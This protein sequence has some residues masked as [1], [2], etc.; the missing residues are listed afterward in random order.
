V[1][2]LAAPADDDVIDPFGRSM[3]TYERSAAEL[4]PAVAAVARVFRLSL[5]GN[6][7]V[8]D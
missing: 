3:Q 1:L 7:T 8:A 5:A 2:P 6:T 4:D